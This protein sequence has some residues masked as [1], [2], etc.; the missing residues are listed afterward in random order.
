MSR[1]TLRKWAALAIVA[2]VAL[3]IGQALVGM[4]YYGE[5]EAYP[6]FLRAIQ[7]VALALVL[8]S[9]PLLMWALT[10]STRGET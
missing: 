6:W 4:N 10:R 8:G 7:W 1:R 5:E 3:W 2:A 9:L